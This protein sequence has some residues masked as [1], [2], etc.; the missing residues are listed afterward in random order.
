[1]PFII[2]KEHQWIKKKI[3]HP[4]SRYSFWVE[5][6]CDQERIIFH[7]ITGIQIV[8]STLP[9]DSTLFESTVLCD[10]LLLVSDN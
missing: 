8:S 3:G 6:L 7:Y 9:G 10:T 1:M 2:G 4:L 5:G